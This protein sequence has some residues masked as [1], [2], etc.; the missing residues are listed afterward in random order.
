MT[1][2]LS[3]L[4]FILLAARSLSAQPG[5]TPAAR[6]DSNPKEAGRALAET[7]RSSVPAEN[8]F[9]NGALKIRNGDDPIRVVPISVRIIAGA[10]PWQVIYEAGATNNHAVA[11]KLVIRHWP[12]RPNE[13]LYL[14]GPKS[15]ELAKLARNQIWAPFAGSDFWPIDLGLDFF[16]WPEQRLIRLG[17][18]VMR[19]GRP[20]DVLESINL[21]AAPGEYT[22]VVSYLD[23]ETGGPILAEGYD[24]EDKLLKEFSIHS[25]RKV[26]GRWQLQEMEIRN[27]KAHSRTRMEFDL[28]KK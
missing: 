2:F 16:H 15:D 28:Q 19:K 7:L 23:K 24:R 12:D 22:R 14:R 3:T 18:S 8:S 25:F 9:V 6:S 21:K 26:E 10:T 27:L 4:V 20:V 1:R 11:E 13:Y 17:E 5:A